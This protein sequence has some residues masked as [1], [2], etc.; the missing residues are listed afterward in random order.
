[1]SNS[2]LPKGELTLTGTLKKEVEKQVRKPMN[3]NVDSVENVLKS[4]KHR[5]SYNESILEM[6]PDIAR[7]MSIITS[8]ILSPNDLNSTKLNYDINMLLPAEIKSELE[9]LIED[10]IEDEYSLTSKLEDIV[11]RAMF[12]EGAYILATIPSTDILKLNNVAETVGLETFIKKKSKPSSLL[13]KSKDMKLLGLQEVLSA[14]HMEQAGV[15]TSNGA[16]DKKIKNKL[17]ELYKKQLSVF[18]IKDYDSNSQDKNHALSKRLTVD[19]VVPITRPGLPEEHVGYLCLLDSDGHPIQLNSKSFSE[20]QLSTKDNFVKSLSG[21]HLSELTKKTDKLTNMSEIYNV[22]VGNELTKIVDSYVENKVGEIVLSN[23]VKDLMLTR[24]LKQLSTKILYIPK[25][26]LTY[27]AFEYR[28]NGTGKSNLEK[29]RLLASMRASLLMG[30]VAVNLKNSINNTKVSATMDDDETDPDGFMADVR[31]GAFAARSEVTKFGL[32]DPNDISQHLHRAGF[33]FDFHGGGL[34]EYGIEVSNETSSFTEPEGSMEEDLKKQILMAFNLPVTLAEDGATDKLATSIR[35]N[36]A[37]LGKFINLKQ[38]VLNVKLSEHVRSLVTNSPIVLDEI[39]EILSGKTGK[40]KTML[41]ADKKLKDDDVVTWVLNKILATITV[42]LPS[43]EISA[44]DGSKKAFDDKK[45]FVEAAV[46]MYFSD[47]IIPDDF[48]GDIGGTLDDFKDGI[49]NS[50]M[51]GWL[52]DNNFLDELSDIVKV[53]ENGVRY[54]PII[55]DIIK[56]Q[57]DLTTPLLRALKRMKRITNKNN[58]TLDKITNDDGSQDTSD[59]GDAT[60]GDTTD[61][62][63]GGGDATGDTTDATGGDTP[64]ADDGSGL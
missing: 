3:I 15:E 21:N 44:D 43:A 40:I 47:A 27:I 45:D 54:I 58:A 60:G 22:V 7:S 46:E 56:Y 20:K 19:S 41:K 55:E 17:D 9:E 32:L 29:I 2:K 10:F 8:S 14:R 38:R 37:L 28:D 30:R 33:S 51:R 39:K 42:T 13:E 25:D 16:K 6:F 49:T 11:N 26:K 31:A 48:M 64:P 34:P 35:E 1:M 24:A 62:G 5:T 18:E 50:I 23:D 4:N 61:G 63:D 12:T 57:T 36:M 53:N 59:G 52:K